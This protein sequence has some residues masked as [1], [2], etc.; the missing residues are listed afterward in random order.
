MDNH[1]ELRLNQHGSGWMDV[2]ISAILLIL[3]VGFSFFFFVNNLISKW[4]ES[5]IF[6]L[7]RCR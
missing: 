4:H 7:I 1:S 5:Y 6:T 3:V 2:K